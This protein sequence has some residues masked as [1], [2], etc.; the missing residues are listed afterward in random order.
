MV[1]SPVMAQAVTATVRAVKAA[2]KFIP[3]KAAIVLVSSTT[4]TALPFIFTT[5]LPSLDSVSSTES[6]V[7]SGWEQRCSE[8]R[9]PRVQG[10]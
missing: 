3:R 4:T 5:Y 6:T 9:V 8:C 7:T 2:R 1:I 10:G